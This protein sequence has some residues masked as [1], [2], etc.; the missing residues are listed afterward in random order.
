MA[1]ECKN[2][3]EQVIK[4]LA[5]AYRDSEYAS[6]SKAK[7]AHIISDT[8][9]LLHHGPM[10]LVANSMWGWNVYFESKTIT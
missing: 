6:A 9:S 7:I 1:L 4:A 8:V 3:T 10:K 2:S 5:V